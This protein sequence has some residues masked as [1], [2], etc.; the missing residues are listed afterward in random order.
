MRVFLTGSTGWVGS[1]VADELIAAGHHVRGLARSADKAAALQEKGGEVVIGSIE[2]TALLTTEARAA[3][4]VIHTAFNHDFTRFAGA[5]QADA[6]AIAAMGEPLTGT[7]KPILITSGVTMLKPGSVV[8]EQDGFQSNAALP[9]Q[10]EVAAGALRERG[11]K[12]SL[13]RLSPSVHGKGDQGFIR[14][15]IEF[16]RQSGVSSYIGDGAN[17]WPAVSRLDAAALYRIAMETADLAP[18]YHAVG[19]DG[20]TPFKQIATI[21]GR[22]LG[23]PL[24]PRAPEHFGFL[25]TLVAGD[26]PASSQWTQ[27]TL[28]WKP[29]HPELLQDLELDSYYSA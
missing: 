17:R 10:S 25:A 22:K 3:D 11:V 7:G 29:D 21:I 8:T 19:N 24:E 26:M 9:R 23:L 16:A 20:A 4:A 1:A 27:K 12:A 13:I 5:A 6:L 14:R 15:V 18:V 28:G 2:D